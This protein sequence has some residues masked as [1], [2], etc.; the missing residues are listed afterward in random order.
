MVYLSP[1][2]RRDHGGIVVYFHGDAADYSADIANNY[3]RE[4]PAIGMDLKAAMKGSNQIII[5]PR[6]TCWGAT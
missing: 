5:A 6:S 3:S 4:N 1:D 2:L